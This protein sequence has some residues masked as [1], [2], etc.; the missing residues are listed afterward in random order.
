MDFGLANLARASTQ[1][2]KASRYTMNSKSKIQNRGAFWANKIVLPT[3]G[4][5][6]VVIVLSMFVLM[7]IIGL[8]IDGGS[9]YVQRRTAQ[10]SAD[11]AALAATHSMLSS[12]EAMILAYPDDHDGTATDEVAISSTLT[13]YARAHGI[14][15]SNLQAYY[16]NDDKQVVTTT[17]V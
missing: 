6:M 15:R 3:Q 5:A 13:T 8:A 10:N 12:Y 7:V 1:N 14:S 11:A 9:M 2:P 4:Q 16:I 17:Q